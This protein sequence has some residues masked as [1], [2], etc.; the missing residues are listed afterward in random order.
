MNP[1]YTHDGSW[2]WN[3]VGNYV[4]WELPNQRLTLIPE[5]ITWKTSKNTVRNHFFLFA[6]QRVG[7]D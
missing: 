6:F 4:P 7:V 3:V 1:Q 2:S 5:K